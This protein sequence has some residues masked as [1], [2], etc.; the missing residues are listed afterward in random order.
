MEAGTAI[1]KAAQRRR[2]KLFKHGR[3]SRQR[4]TVLYYAWRKVHSP[5][6]FRRNYVAGRAR[7]PLAL[8]EEFLN[9]LLNDRVVPASAVMR[10]LRSDW[11]LGRQIPGLGT[12]KEYV[13]Q[14]R[15]TDCERL[16]PPRFPFSETTLLRS[17][18][19]PKPRD[20]QRRIQ[21]ALQAQADLL[22]FT[23]FI[24]GKRNGIVAQ[25]RH[26]PMGNAIA[27]SG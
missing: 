10:S 18:K 20:Y 24:E 22:R 21:S 8:V 5:E 27:K 7:I 16:T 2:H 17:L 4:L 23:A 14:H 26:E 19:G 13:R 1:R 12:W 11:S 25:R 3:L 6:V 15:G 9:R